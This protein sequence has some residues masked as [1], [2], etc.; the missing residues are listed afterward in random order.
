MGKRSPLPEIKD[1][2]IHLGDDQRI[3]VLEQELQEVNLN[4]HREFQAF[5]T[6]LSVKN[7]QNIALSRKLQAQ[8][9]QL[10]N[11]VNANIDLEKKLTAS[12]SKEGNKCSQLIFAILA[13]I[14]FLI[15]MAY[16]P[17]DVES[18]ANTRN[19]YYGSKGFKK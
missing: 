7:E 14:L 8:A 1:L 2:P 15:Y 19:T 13:I 3:K 11:A 4:S 18:C 16:R 6:E 5:R 9:H 12:R 17:V 10:E